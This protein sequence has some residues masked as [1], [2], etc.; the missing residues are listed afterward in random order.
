MW[1]RGRENLEMS[2]NRKDRCL[3]CHPPSPWQPVQLHRM[4]FFSSDCLKISIFVFF[5]WNL[6]LVECE[7][8]HRG[9][10]EERQQAYNQPITWTQKCHLFF[11][12]QKVCKRTVIDSSRTCEIQNVH[13]RP[14]SLP[15]WPPALSDVSTSW[16]ST[17]DELVKPSTYFDRLV[18][19]SFICS[20]AVFSLIR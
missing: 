16:S 1:K 20:A 13:S 14:V 15:L 2:N 8:S 11:K 9:L 5:V 12:K 19:L 18:L 7:A 4:F 17:L 3:T 10:F 6:N